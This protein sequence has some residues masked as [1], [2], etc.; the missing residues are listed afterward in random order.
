MPAPRSPGWA[1]RLTD[2]LGVRPDEATEADL[3]RL[4]TGGIREDADLDFK[5]ARYGNSD[6][7]RRE[8]A[9][10]IAAMA[11]YRGGVI[12]LGIREEN[13]VA[14]ARTPV[15]LDAG[16]ETRIRQTAASNIAPHLTFEV[17]VVHSPAADQTGY[18]LLIVPPS[19]LRPHA[20]RSGINLRF[21]VRDGTTKRWLSEAEVA[22]AYRSRYRL[23][24]DQAGRV[25][26]IL[27]DGLHMMDHEAGAF[28]ALAMVP[29]G[30]GS[31]PIDLARVRAIEQWIRGLG[32]A[33]RFEGFFDP[34]GTPTADVAA[35]R[36]TV[37]PL[38]Q[39]HGLQKSEY[40][41]LF[42]DGAG[43]A[44]TSMFDERDP[45]GEHAEIWL[46]NERLMWDVGRCLHL[47]GQHAVR[48]CGAW[49]DALIEAKL[50]GKSEQPMRLIFMQRLMHGAERPAEI[51]GGRQLSVAQS[52]HTLVV[53]ATAS[54]GPGLVTATRLFATDLFHA[55][56][57]PEVRQITPDG[58]LRV[59][60]LGGDGALRGWADQH[61]IAVSDESV[62]GE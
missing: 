19:T 4:V 58:A 18:Y 3:D 21:P 15:E 28:L 55:F 44:C 60:H 57:S 41:E 12:V 31:M 39:R 56:G 7:E 54:I 26:S 61:G 37:S 62:A 48:N 38:W 53:E 42:D 14:V 22:D 23:A 25:T 40:V 47:L 35:H 13:E 17:K 46:L 16:E 33:S 27:G 24:A 9:A 43:F 36:V 59:R 34:A 10:D 20:V 11:N 51:E 5:Q 52:Q 32:P 45:A 50:V 6:G 1:L 8:M 29:T 30:L 49:G 2:L